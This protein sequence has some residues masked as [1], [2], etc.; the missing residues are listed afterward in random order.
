MEALIAELQ[1]QMAELKADNAEMKGRIK[2][3]ESMLHID[4]GT[5][6]N[7]D[8]KMSGLADSIQQTQDRNDYTPNPLSAAGSTV[9]GYAHDRLQ[10]AVQV[11]SARLTETPTNFHQLVVF[12]LS[13]PVDSTDARDVE[14]RKRG[15]LLFCISAAMVFFQSA[16]AAAVMYGTRSQKCQDNDH[17]PRDGTYCRIGISGRCNFCGDKI[18]LRF[19]VNES[20]GETYNRV[21]DENF[22]GYNRTHVHEL[23][24]SPRETRYVYRGFSFPF[25]E[26][27]VTSWCDAC[28]HP[29]TMSVDS[30]TPESHISS[31]LSAMG[32]SD[33]FAFL[34]AFA[35]IALSVA[36]ELK[37]VYW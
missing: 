23:C 6:S 1:L 12:A 3:L 33:W 31:I 24:S 7:F 19:D 18:P 21:D 30:Q 34:V 9:A 37:G 4:G 10:T 32:R 28:V 17:C 16:A 36:G 20:N 26:E 13:R 22:A 25:T 2:Q 8:L 5:P 14:L 15:A 35:V 29:L 27:A 11:A